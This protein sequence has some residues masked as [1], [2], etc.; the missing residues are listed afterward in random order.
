M[1]TIDLSSD[2]APRPLLNTLR[3]FRIDG[4][5]F[6][7][8]YE[9]INEIQTGRIEML[10]DLYQ[11][12]PSTH[13][14]FFTPAKL[15]NNPMLKIHIFSMPYPLY[16]GLIYKNSGDSHYGIFT[17]LE[18]KEQNTI[19]KIMFSDEQIIHMRNTHSLKKY[20]RLIPPGKAW[21]ILRLIKGKNMLVPILATILLHDH[22]NQDQVFMEFVSYATNDADHIKRLL[23]YE[24]SIAYARYMDF[25]K[26]ID[27]SVTMDYLEFSEKLQK[28]IFAA[29]KSVVSAIRHGTVAPN[30]NFFKDNIYPLYMA[31]KDSLQDDI[32]FWM[33][34]VSLIVRLRLGL[35][36]WQDFIVNQLPINKVVR[37]V[38]LELYSNRHIDL[39]PLLLLHRKKF[40]DHL[41]PPRLHRLTRK[42]A[43]FLKEFRFGI[44]TSRPTE[45]TYPLSSIYQAALSARWYMLNVFVKYEQ[46]HQAVT[47][48]QMNAFIQRAESILRAVLEFD[49]QLTLHVIAAWPYALFLK[50]KL[51]MGNLFNQ[52]NSTDVWTEWVRNLFESPFHILQVERALY[53]LKINLFFTINDLRLLIDSDYIN[54]PV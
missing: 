42:R 4:L 30:V 19:L 16:Q 13:K 54:K 34:L 1:S 51:P 2:Q 43:R 21:T 26:A 8:L 18:A 40:P 31:L 37:L 35:S 45:F 32:S 41:L 12:H 3:L 47:M 49:H 5:Q 22:S 17:N 6:Q 53:N 52:K 20:L 10:L 25:L 36:S 46:D 11:K 29:L 24:L 23:I 38:F 27:L 44:D 28:P 39:F 15:A 9:D 48:T 7:K 14:Y 50:H 33:M